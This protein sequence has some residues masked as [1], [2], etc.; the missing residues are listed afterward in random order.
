MQRSNLN[1]LAKPSIRSHLRKSAVGFL[2]R[3]AFSERP[4]HLHQGVLDQGDRDRPALPRLRLIAAEAGNVGR[5][6]EAVVGLFWIAFLAKIATADDQLDR[7]RYLRSALQQSAEIVGQGFM[8]FEIKSSCDCPRAL[9]RARRVR[10][11][12]EINVRDKLSRSVKDLFFRQDFP[13]VP[14]IALG[15]LQGKS[16]GIDPR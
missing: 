13:A 3:F 9:A 7:R 4:R 14:K 15:S 12:Y 11:E 5:D 2:F 16:C 1:L 6:A 10:G 8:S